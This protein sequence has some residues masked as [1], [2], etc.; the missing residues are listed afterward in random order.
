MNLPDRLIVIARWEN[1]SS[2]TITLQNF[3]AESEVFIPVF[4]DEERF[5]TEAAGSGYEHEG[6]SIETDVLRQMLRGDELLILNPGSERRRMH[7]S[8]L[9]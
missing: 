6:V 5:H 2:Q 7:K 3:T 1:D 9:G 8:D 4:S